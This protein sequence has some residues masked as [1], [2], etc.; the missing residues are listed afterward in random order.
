MK[1]YTM[2]RS[3]L[4]VVAIALLALLLTVPALAQ[5]NTSPPGPGTGVEINWP[6]PVTEVWG[7]GDVV[8]TASVPGMAYYYLEYVELN[9]DLTIPQNA[10][11]IPATAALAQPISQ[12]ALATLDTTRVP[13]GLYALR[14]VVLTSAGDVYTDTVQPVRVNNTRMLDYTNRVIAE[15]LA[16]YGIIVD[17]GDEEETTSQ[18]EPVVDPVVPTVMP[19]GGVTAVNVRY[20]DAVDNNGC[21]VIGALDYAGAAIVA[22]SSS[23]TGWF[24]IQLPSGLQGWVSPTVV[25]ATGNLAAL[26]MSTPPAPLPPPT[27]PNVVVNGI[28]TQG[29][30]E[31]GLP[32]TVVV[33]VANVGDALSSEGSV[34]LQD[35]NTRTGEITATS[36]GG[37]P[38]LNPGE[39]FVV[40]F[41]ISTVVYY[42]ETHELRAYGGSSEVRFQYVLGQGNCVVQPTPPPPPPPPA[43]TDFNR[44]QCFIVLTQ[45]WPA[46]GAPYGELIT[47]L[48][49]RA[50]EATGLQIIN[51]EA[52]Y[53]IEPPELGEVWVTRVNRLTQGNCGVN[54]LR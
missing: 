13:D 32:F 30:T 10:P 45:P 18:P 38:P 15:T 19:A 35:I 51:G 53:R 31:C 9:P 40:S 39:N 46:F 6:P 3:R 28:N 41:T 4:Y 14:L 44:D 33:N 36:Y 48:A 12:G 23:G 50:W 29:A 43:I 8:G 22:T 52:W 54:P 34:T 2:H 1:E 25:E 42:N 7:S 27:I 11:W 26:P 21:P 49:A 37:Y 17:E 16:A 5:E 24:L 47:Q 20:C